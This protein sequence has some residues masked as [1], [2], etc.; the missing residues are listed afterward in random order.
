VQTLPRE[1]FEQ[2]VAQQG[3]VVVAFLAE[4]CPFC[5]QFEGA[6]QAA[7]AQR[8]GTPFAI[9][10]ISDDDTDP[11]WDAYGIRVVPTVIVFLDGRPTARIDGILGRGI[12]PG[13]LER[14]LQAALA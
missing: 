5:A 11:R 8:P 1:D 14:G 9:A 3:K 4:W 6:Y 12:S 10:D 13:E 2:R 7:A